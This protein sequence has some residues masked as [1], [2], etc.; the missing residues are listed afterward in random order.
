MHQISKTTISMG[1]YVVSPT[2]HPTDCGRFRASFS[3]HRSQGNGSYCRVFR[4]DRAFASREA[5]LACQAVW[6]LSTAARDEGA[7]L[8]A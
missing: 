4:F 6:L 7:A 8:L 5:A 2:T 3:V 1:K